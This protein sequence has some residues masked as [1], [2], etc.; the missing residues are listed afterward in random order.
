MV[1]EML[2]WNRSIKNCLSL[3]KTCQMVNFVYVINKYLKFQIF[4]L[5]KLSKVKFQNLWGC[6][7]VSRGRRQVL[8][9]FSQGGK[10]LT[11]RRVCLGRIGIRGNYE[12]YLRKRLLKSI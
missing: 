9:L 11:W 7:F 1:I 12:L 5:L 6:C 10:L 2:A 3:N 8:K 4:N